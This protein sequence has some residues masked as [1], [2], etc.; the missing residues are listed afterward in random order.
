MPWLPAGMR[1]RLGT[2]AL[3]LG[4]YAAASLLSFAAFWSQARVGLF[5]PD[6][7]PA[8]Y[9]LGARALQQD[10]D[11]SVDVVWNFLF[12]T[13]TMP[14]PGFELW[15]PGTSVAIAAVQWVLDDSYA[16]ACT[17]A[18]LFGTIATVLSV[19][20]A[21]RLLR[22][23]PLALA[24]GGLFVLNERVM[25]H[26]TSPDSTIFYTVW[27]LGFLTLIGASLDRQG[28]SRIALAAGAGIAAAAAVLTRNDA[29]VTLPFTLAL[30]AFVWRRQGKRQRL[31]RSDLAVV[32]GSFAAALLPWS[33]RCQCAF[34]TLWSPA[35]SKT[36]W[37]IVYQDLFAYPAQTTGARYLEHVASHPWETLVDKARG[38]YLLLYWMGDMIG[39]VVVPLVI[40]G[41][42]LTLRNQRRFAATG[43]AL[44]VSLVLALGLIADRL[45]AGGSHRSIV[46]LLPYL[47]A[48]ALA[49][50]LFGLRYVFRGAREKVG[51]KVARWLG[52]ALAASVWLLVAATA[53]A[54]LNSPEAS[55]FEY[56]QA[57][58]Y[59]AA[60]ASLRRANV[61]GPVLAMQPA[62]ASYGMNRPSVMIPK[63]N[64]DDVCA[65]ADVFG[66][67]SMVLNG[68]YLDTPGF[69]VL[70]DLHRGRQRDPRARPL[71]A[72][73][74]WVVFE[75][76]C[77]TEQ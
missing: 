3:R 31:T 37:L 53:I 34:G 16:S 44:F 33:V 19:A 68:Y 46:P 71:S 75:L 57:M 21:R 60:E 64:L 22:N 35:S 76:R 9:V 65:A 17:A 29:L 72:Q 28:R 51:D 10:H 48:F 25:L 49:L 59:G 32:G 6:S 58:H 61:S 20:V 5:P 1:T 73:D 62:M 7:D 74:A 39:V 23:W 12:V 47:I 77:R 41:A 45:V 43:L 8:Y 50:P 2:F 70:R 55:Y 67:G 30:V 11:L 52:I 15:M 56:Q 18:A 69:E 13:P 38:A 66:A 26:A 40:A 27:V 36:P 42:V 4:P 54:R 24:C 63:G 14:Q